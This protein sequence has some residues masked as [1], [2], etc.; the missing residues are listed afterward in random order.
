MDTFTGASAYQPLSHPSE[1]RIVKV[2]LGKFDDPI[3]CDLRHVRLDKKPKYYDALS[4]AWG[5]LLVTTPI[6]LKGLNYP[7]TTNLSSA[8]RYLRHETSPIYIWIDALCINQT[9]LIEKSEEIPRMFDIYRA[10]RCV[11][12]W[13]GDYADYSEARV[14]TIFEQI[15]W[16]AKAFASNW[17]MNDAANEFELANLDDRTAVKDAFLNLLER[18]WFSRKWVIQEVASSP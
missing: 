9:D 17:S 16:T 13:I 10:A 6:S 1:I 4:Y 3:E 15:K 5:D 2:L 14:H 11:I 7:V 18:P 8:L 12:A